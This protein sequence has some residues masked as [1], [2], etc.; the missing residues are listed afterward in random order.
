MPF[1]KIAYVRD[2][3][4]RS[5]A[6]EFQIR[7]ASPE[8]ARRFLGLVAPADAD[9]HLEQAVAADGELLCR[10]LF[11]SELPRSFFPVGPPFDDLDF[12]LFGADVDVG[13]AE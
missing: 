12:D 1:R 11:R 3:L 10:A 4:D 5:L 6:I 7:I 2:D 8:Q 13:V 9:R